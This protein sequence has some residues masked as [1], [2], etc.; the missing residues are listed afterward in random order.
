M[1]VNHSLKGAICIK[2]HLPPNNEGEAT[3]RSCCKR[4]SD[5]HVNVFT[6]A[7]RRTRTIAQNIHQSQTGTKQDIKDIIK[8]SLHHNDRIDARFA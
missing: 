4:T 8:E 7:K 6:S 1:K 5:G 3:E 2:D